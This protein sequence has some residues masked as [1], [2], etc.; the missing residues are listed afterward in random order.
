ML[1]AG[2]AKQRWEGQ[3]VRSAHRLSYLS[4]LLLAGLALIC[5]LLERSDTLCVVVLQELAEP[6]QRVLQVYVLALEGLLPV[7]KVLLLQSEGCSWAL[8]AC[9][10]HGRV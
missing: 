10:L 7:S 4:F 6:D 2:P 3:G 1:L 9:Q 5:R 8:A